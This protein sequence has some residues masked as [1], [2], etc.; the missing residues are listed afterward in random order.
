MIRLR[1]RPALM[2]LC[3]VLLASAAAAQDSRTVVILV[4]HAE[5]A[6]EPADDP[7]LTPLGQTRAEE[8]AAV[9]A[10]AG[11]TAIYSTQYNRTRHTAEA[12]AR[13]LG[14]DVRVRPIAAGTAEAHSR[15]MA[16]AIL[17]GHVGQTVLVVGHSN[18]VPLLAR[19]LGAADP[20][21]IAD[22]EYD[23]LVIVIVGPGARR[24]LI[25]A[26]Y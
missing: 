25:R 16:E 8:L 4:R 9:L 13:R 3:A 23:N 19:A 6:T 21:A 22:D 10:D 15:Q 11:I 12:V 26:R 24:D 1:H 20:G 14:L 5:R 2:G 17:A 7:G 18:T